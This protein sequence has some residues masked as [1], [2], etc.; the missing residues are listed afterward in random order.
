MTAGAEASGGVA[1]STPSAPRLRPAAFEDYDRI[2]RVG[3]ALSFKNQPRDDWSSVWLENPV[4]PQLGKGWPIGWVLETAKGEIVGSV[5][6][7]PSKYLFQ[8]QELVCGNARGWGVRPEFRGY[9]LAL[10][11]EYFNQP[12]VDL[13]INTTVNPMAAPV[14]ERVCARVPLGDWQTGSYWVTRHLEFARER[15]RMRGALVASVLTYPA[16]GVFWLRDSMRKSPFAKTVGNIDIDVA[17]RF[18]A[19]FD[20]FWSELVRENHG[21]LL[22]ERSSRALS[23]HFGIPL[24]RGQITI[25]T[26]S[27]NR[28]LRAYCILNRKRG[29]WRMQLADYQ[30]LEREMDLL[31]ALLNAALRRCAACDVYA[32]QNL[33][34]G[35]PKMRAFDDNA[36]YR[37]A[38]P[39]WKFFYRVADPS[40]DATLRQPQ[41]WD[42]SAYD[43]DASL[44]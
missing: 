3:A 41:C 15:L 9:A 12:G 30:T 2:M 16:A 43:G 29:G 11:D 19:R 7:V 10:M 26:A 22:S 33:G 13:F 40:L 34:S 37:E 39:N 27:R 32:L 20:T 35:V 23:W 44:A 8:G 1:S 6:N 21:K 5:V 4:W 25:I 14:I 18:D 31:P 42:P 38:L 17:N 36:P 28:Q 24:R